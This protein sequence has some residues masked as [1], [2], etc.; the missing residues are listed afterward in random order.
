MLS[1][2]NLRLSDEQAVT[3]SA[4]S[5]NTIDLGSARDIGE[6]HPLY[7]VFT[8]TE[9]FATLTSLE[10]QI[11]TDDNAALSSGTSIAT[12]GSITLA[13][14]GLAAGQQH[15]VVI[16]P[17]IASLGEQYLGANFAVTGANA[18]AGKVTTD[19]VEHIQDGQKFYPSGSVIL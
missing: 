3:A 4:V 16:P 15:T 11:I 12:S 18:T 17:Q 14:G 13:G 5:E 19:I 10:F 2:I 6:G 7:M 9:T 1:D 8:V